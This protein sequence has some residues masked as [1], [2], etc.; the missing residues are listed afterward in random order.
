M[1]A[2]LVGMYCSPTEKNGRKSY[3]IIITA[4]SMGSVALA[5]ALA[6][7]RF[8]NSKPTILSNP[9][10]SAIAIIGIIFALLILFQH[11]KTLAKDY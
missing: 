3:T 10:E 1:I 11:W 8:E 9:I 4:F 5:G 2:V 6:A 7:F